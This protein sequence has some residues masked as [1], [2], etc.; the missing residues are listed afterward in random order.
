MPGLPALFAALIA[1]PPPPPPEP[2]EVDR[3]LNAPPCP[4][5][6]ATILF[7]VYVDHVTVV[8][9]P[10]VIAAPP[11]PIYKEMESFPVSETVV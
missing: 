1:E 6:T 10:F 7:D 11:A 3:L 9:L 5:P 8:L 2:P 4:P